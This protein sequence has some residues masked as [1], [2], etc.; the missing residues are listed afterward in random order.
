MLWLAAGVGIVHGLFSL[1]WALGGR[2]LLDTVGAWAVDLAVDAPVAAGIV[3]ALIAVV[4][5][6]GATVPLLVESD[7]MSGRRGWR[8]AEWVGAAVLVVYGLANTVVAWFVLA[9]VIVPD[10]GYDRAAM[11]G[12]A[13]LWD[14]LF[15]CWG[16]FLG[17]GL[18]L[19]RTPTFTNPRPLPG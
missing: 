14:P 15:L 9:G 8:V 5:F 7:R 10:G 2:W 1:Y 16:L 3:L 11:I 6:A 13:A 18:A 4:K 19:T 17:A 12:H